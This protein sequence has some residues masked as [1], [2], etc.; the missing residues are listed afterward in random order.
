MVASNHPEAVRVVRPV[1]SVLTSIIPKRLGR[2]CIG[3]RLRKEVMSYIYGNVSCANFP[4][5]NNVPAPFVNPAV[6]W[7]NDSLVFFFY[8][9][10]M[11][12]KVLGGDLAKRLLGADSALTP[13]SFLA[14]SY[15][16]NK[17]RYLTIGV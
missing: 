3:G 6:V 17:I 1:F 13:R 16:W 15:P 11:A 2:H 14:K 4:G 12:F 8:F 7:T 10:E 5:N 9:R